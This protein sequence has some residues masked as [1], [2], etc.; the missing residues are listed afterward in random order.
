MRQNAPRLRGVSFRFRGAHTPSHYARRQ[1]TNVCREATMRKL[2]IASISAGLFIQT[3]ARAQANSSSIR[4]AWQA[5][6]VTMTGPNPRT[7]SIPEPRPNLTLITGKHYSHIQVESEGPR[8]AIADLAKASAD[9]L[10][11]T[12]G[13]F[14]GDAGTYEIASNTITTHPIVSKNP[15]AMAKGA[16]TV[17]AIKQ[18]GDTLWMT[19]QRTHR[20]AVANPWTIKMVRVE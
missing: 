1:I 14:S 17:Y 16:F 10:R 9:E 12:W 15:A 6:Q 5:I 19:E 11:A 18:Q 13:P 20:G 8:P 4:G 7:I 2:L 3:E